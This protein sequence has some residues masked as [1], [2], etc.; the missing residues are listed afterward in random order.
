MLSLR[1]V[2]LVRFHLEFELTIEVARLPN[3]LAILGGLGCLCLHAVSEDDLVDVG[4][5]GDK[6]GGSLS[7]GC[8][9]AELVEVG[10]G[11]LARTVVDASTL[12]N[13][14]DTVERSKMLSETW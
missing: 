11:E 5:G 14:S 2:L 6:I 8:V 10:T 13:D 9:V 1:K 3:A 12:V 4:E 7:L